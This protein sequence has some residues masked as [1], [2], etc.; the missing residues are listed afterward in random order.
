MSNKPVPSSSQKDPSP[1]KPS[2]FC[3]A[4]CR[5]TLIFCLVLG[6]LATSLLLYYRPWQ[7]HTLYTGEIN[8][9]KKLTTALDDRINHLESSGKTHK[10]ALTSPDSEQI[11]A[12]ENHIIALQQ[13]VEAL[14]NQPKASEASGQLEQSQAFEKNLNQ[15]AE[16]QKIIKTTLIFWRL[17]N[18]ALSN[19][20]YASELTAYKT[21][22][23]S[24]ETL[25]LLE[26]YADHG[27]KILEG[28][29]EEGSPA[30]L[31]NETASWWDRVKTTARSLIKIEKVDLPVAQ[32]VSSVQDRQMIE[33][34][35]SQIDQKL[36]QQ[37]DAA[38]PGDV[39]K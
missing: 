31:E 38:L 32:P 13:Q 33:D 27:L 5:N 29:P 19:A 20:P 6:I 39:L 9:L 7:I 28:T 21:V 3:W 1:S 17:K 14:Q 25:S 10:T 37:L 2:K 22:S 26:K 24:G 18:K 4:Q 34:L 36:A 12:F 16:T 23:K 8:A 35:L 11:H 30:S 15:L